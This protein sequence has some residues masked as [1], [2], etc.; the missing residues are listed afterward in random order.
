M[1]AHHRFVDHEL[2]VMIS[3]QK[4][5]SCY[6]NGDLGREDRV[7]PTKPAVS[8]KVWSEIPHR[9]GSPWSGTRIIGPPFNVRA[10]SNQPPNH[11]P[12]DDPPR[13]RC[14][15]VAACAHPDEPGGRADLELPS[16]T[17]VPGQNL[18]PAGYEG[19]Y[20]VLA[21]VLE[22]PEHGPQLCYAVATSLPPQCG[23]PDIVGWDWDGLEYESAS[24]TRWGEY[25][26]TGK[27][28][29]A[30]ETF[31]LTEPPLN[32]DEAPESERPAGPE[33]NFGTPCPAPDGGWRPLDPAKAAHEA[34]ERA[35]SAARAEP[36]FAGA[37]LDQ[38]YLTEPGT[39][40]GEANDPQ[41]LVLN[42]RFTGDL[43]RHETQIREIWG[44]AICVIP[45]VYSLAD[46]DDIRQ[47]VT[48][49]LGQLSS[50]VDEVTGTVHVTLTVATEPE[51]SQLD[52]R[53]GP[54]VVILTGWLRPID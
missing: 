3:S 2:R 11:P 23:G 46:R 53:F 10:P 29:A 47:E 52:A 1:T 40:E 38:S 21:T 20:R 31:T 32:G 9:H 24:G 12:R 27:W 42:L 16:P 30:A 41:R 8:L 5:L 45:A 15:A 54:G 14:Q 35:I 37:W 50:T 44:G 28:D 19:R 49:A 25:L 36:D 51:Q 17:P 22:S 34:L 48:A 43:V 4:A 26:V 13:R 6:D 7:V 18:V 39:A 33:T